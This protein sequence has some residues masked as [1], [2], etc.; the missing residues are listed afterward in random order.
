MFRPLLLLTVA[1]CAL[2]QGQRPAGLY[3]VFNT[4]AGTF[5]AKLQEKD[6]RRTV[7]NFVAL[8]QGTK[9][10]AD[11]V[12][13]KMVQRPLY[14]NITFHRVIRGTAIQAGDPTGLG[15]HNCGVKL[16]DE[17]LPGLRFDRGGVLAM[18]NSGSPD[19]GGCQFFI[20]L[21]PMAS[22]TGNYTVFGQVVS[23][24]DVVEKIGNAAVRD[25]KPLEPVKLIGVTIEREGP[26]PKRRK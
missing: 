13:R 10:W 15:T 11:P 26:E 23:G 9:P 21:S 5:T 2:A 17:I 6:V 3:A 12:A 25:E 8:A 1:A 7:E 19:S 16:Q 18:A 22:W 4:S 14:N 24:M 20:T